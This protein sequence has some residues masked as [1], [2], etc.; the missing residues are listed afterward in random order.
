[1]PSRVRVIPLPISADRS[2]HGPQVTEGYLEWFCKPLQHLPLIGSYFPSRHCT[3]L[4]YNHHKRSL[5]TS[6]VEPAYFLNP[7][8]SWKSLSI[9]DAYNA[10]AKGAVL[11]LAPREDEEEDEEVH[12]RLVKVLQ[13]DFSGGGDIPRVCWLG[14]AGAFL[15]I[16]W[17]HGSDDGMCGVMFDPI[18]SK[19]CSPSQYFGPARFLDPPCAIDELP[20]VHVVC[21][22][23]DHYDHLDYDT[24]MT[25]YHHNQSIQF[26]VP[27][28]V[29]K[30]F[31]DSKIPPHQVTELDWFQEAVVNVTSIHRDD[32]SYSNSSASSS[33]DLSVSAR[34]TDSS[35]V[36][37]FGAKDARHTEQPTSD[38]GSITLKI[39]CTPAQHRS[40]RGIL[41]QMRTLWSSWVVG[42][43]T[44]EMI[45][46]ESGFGGIDTF[47][48]FFGG[49]TGYRYAGAP[50]I[51]THQAIC[52]AFRE[53]AR[54]YGP[55]TL[56]LL[57]IST[58][59]SLTFLRTTLGISLHHY[60]LT[61][62]QHSNAWDAIQIAKL[63]GSK[64][65]I[66]I[67]HSTFSPEDESRGCVYE[68][69]LTRNEEGVSGTWGEDGCFVVVDI[70]E[71]L[72]VGERID[73]TQKKDDI[74]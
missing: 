16:P 70:G 58:G 32:A 41:D 7:W 8:P 50:E 62:P 17:R 44:D 69:D 19:R 35:R 53:I 10:F 29:K 47:K 28:G 21:I 55:V 22:S 65:T 38:P 20:P 2:H 43:V 25:V 46:T 66:A 59:S 68:F 57:P 14:H 9:A 39:V 56:S 40:G 15:Q 37:L 11:K 73:E 60:S 67:H 72:E 31:T 54:R 23:H 4:E 3:P 64:A 30:W 33:S 52:P 27:L 24:I 36:P 48:V 63:L 1:M 13:P 51:D 6:D 26:F 49:D 42:V 61:S 18:F 5:P 12:G 45:A 71:V 74:V 34:A